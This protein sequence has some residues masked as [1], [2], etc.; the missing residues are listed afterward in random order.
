LEPMTIAGALIGADLNDFLPDY[1]IVILLFLL[2]SLT[3]YKTLQKAN[4]LHEKE[5]EEMEKQEMESL[6]LLANVTAPDVEQ[7]Q[8]SSVIRSSYGTVATRRPNAE[9][10][11]VKHKA[12]F[13]AD[14]V[15]QAWISASQLTGLFV[16]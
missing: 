12:S 14:K 2:L 1:A 8:H 3:A 15:A 4:K 10:T 6:K 9:R 7:A 13:G 11:I 16:V 5:T